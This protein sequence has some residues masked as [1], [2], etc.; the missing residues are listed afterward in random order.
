MMQLFG[1]EEVQNMEILAI[2]EPSIN[3]LVDPETT[4]SCILWGRFHVL[5]Q[6]TSMTE[7]RRGLR[8]RTC[9]YVNKDIDPKTWS[10]QHYT[11]DLSTLTLRLDADSSILN[12][13]KAS[14]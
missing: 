9:S 10:F 11:R 8:P 12:I 4:Y 6:S 14:H 1:E 3:K 2:Q 5:L 13:H 7:C